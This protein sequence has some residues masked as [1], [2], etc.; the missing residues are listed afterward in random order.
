MIL[1]SDQYSKFINLLLLQLEH[2]LKFLV[3]FFNRLQPRCLLR[4]LPVRFSGSAS[5]SVDVSGEPYLPWNRW[6]KAS[7]SSDFF[8]IPE[9]VCQLIILSVGNEL[10]IF[11]QLYHF[12]KFIFGFSNDHLCNNNLPGFSVI[13]PPMPKEPIF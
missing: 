9:G 5:I 2:G 8:R 4:L 3:P 1:L 13:R 10:S 12:N 11:S 6:A 7:C